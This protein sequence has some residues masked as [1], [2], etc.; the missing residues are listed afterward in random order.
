MKAERFAA[1]S[2]TVFLALVGTVLGSSCSSKSRE[3]TPNN[4]TVSSIPPFRTKE[5][6]RYRAV[7]TVTSTDPAGNTRVIKTLIARSGNLR[8]E[9]TV[10]DNSASIVVLESDQGRF[11]LIPRSRI[12]AVVE[13]E[14]VD[15]AINTAGFDNSPERLL[16]PGSV[17]TS[18]QSL[19]SEQILGR[20]ANK[21]L[22]IV[23]TAHAEN[24]TNSE[25]LIWIDD[26]IGMPIR[27]ETKATNGSRLLM[28]VSDLVLEVDENAFRLPSGYEKVAVKDLRRRQEKLTQ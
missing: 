18:Y 4:P 17:T 19:G 22:V 20:T 7:R 3:I 26:S 11:V 9:E 24:V 21:Y 10:Y 25:T 12:Y 16:H 13:G 14:N 15:A 5:P 28:E 2:G 27:S 8:R 6:E 1:V 23:N